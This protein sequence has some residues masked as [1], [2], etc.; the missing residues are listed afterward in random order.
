MGAPLLGLPKSI[1][2][3]QINLKALFILKLRQQQKETTRLLL[4]TLLEIQYRQFH[5][6]EIDLL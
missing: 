3:L 1:Y 2:I 4:V 6:P 5:G